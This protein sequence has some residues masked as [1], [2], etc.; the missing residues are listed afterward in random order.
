[1]GCED[2][3]PIKRTT[4]LDDLSPP[5]ILILLSV[6]AG[7]PAR[8]PFLMPQD[9]NHTIMLPLIN[10]ILCHFIYLSTQLLDKKYFIKIF[11]IVENFTLQAKSIGRPGRD[12]EFARLFFLF[13]VRFMSETW[14]KF[15]FMHGFF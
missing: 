11:T 6:G 13:L 7:A 14:K 15:N 1:M 10:D 2:K 5:S 9:A 12:I 8:L 4:A 3:E